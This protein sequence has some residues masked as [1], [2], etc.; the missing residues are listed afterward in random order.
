MNH[1]IRY[2][3]GGFILYAL[4]GCAPNSEE[5][6]NI[7]PNFLV[8]LCDDL[9]YAD[10]GF[11][12]GRDVLTPAIDRLASEGMVFTD[13]YVAHPFCGPSRAA[14]MTGRYP[15]EIGTPYNLRDDGYITDNGVP[16]SEVFIS[17]VL[18]DAGYY[19]AAIGKWHLGFAKPFQPYNR[20]FDSFY[21]FLG[22]GHKYFPAQYQPVYARQKKAGKYPI[23][24][25]LMPLLRD[26]TEVQETEYLTD[27][28]SR[29]A[30]RVINTATTKHQPFFLYLAYNAPHVPL[31]AKKED[32]KKFAYIKDK[33]RRTYAA[34]V[35][36]VDRGIKNIVQAL[37]DTHQYDNTMIVF[38]SD[39]GGNT[40]HGA[41]NAPLRGRKG[42]T[43]EGGYRS[44]MFVHWPQRIS[45]EGQY[46][47]PVSSLDL[48]PTLANLAKASITSNKQLDGQ[49]ISTSILSGQPPA[50]MRMIY[51][52]RY[53]DSYCDIGARQGD[54]KIVR[55]G[56]AP[57]RL[58]NIT[59]DIGE[60]HDVSSQFPDRVVQ[61]KTATKKWTKTHVTPLWFYTPEDQQ[62]W[63][64]GILPGYDQAFGN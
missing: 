49:D 41:N 13:A 1:F 62:M 11:N 42:D 23:N 12:G 50:N 45:P 33:D 26:T 59:K 51:A 24:V 34:M 43:W 58:Y 19:T 6:S 55:M 37:K 2:V 3:L 28:F 64:E 8:I 21:G 31:E 22:G 46:H 4:G 56:A 52:L 29:E 15:Q 7:R 44:P 20:G 63:Q 5:S 25:Y 10:V 53:R 61:M 36:A 14:L 9:G 47:Y 48:Y 35:Y 57:W 54:W 39:N 38:L 60:E 17:K 30:V 16:V 18:H 27:A 32:L 40:D